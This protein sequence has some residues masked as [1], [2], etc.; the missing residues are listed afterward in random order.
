MH[1][2]FQKLDEEE[3]YLRILQQFAEIVENTAAIHS[4]RGEGPCPPSHS[5]SALLPA[6]KDLL[7]ALERLRIA[8]RGGR[9][10]RRP[11]ARPQRQPEPAG[12]GLDCPLDRA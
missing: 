9:G 2:L 3:E 4:P 1:F 8:G 12:L 11:P 10:Q 5:Q 7:R 6:H